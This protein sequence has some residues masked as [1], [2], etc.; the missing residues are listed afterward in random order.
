M[1]RALGP[2]KYRP[3]TEYL[4]ALSVYEVTLTLA[5]IE[6]LLGTPLPVS[7]QLAHVWSDHRRGLFGVR[8]R[9]HQS[10]NTSHPMK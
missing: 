4:A 5:E 1:A 8:L 3:L 10:G 9:C 7:A 6:Q 2:R